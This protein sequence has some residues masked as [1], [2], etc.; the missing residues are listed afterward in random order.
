[1]NNH[2]RAQSALIALQAFNN[3]C[4]NGDLDEVASD[5]LCNLMHLL[6]D[7]DLGLSHLLFSQ[8]LEQAYRSYGGEQ[9]EL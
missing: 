1:M 7:P 9:H 2:K 5:L 8:Q 4:P 6:D 3:H